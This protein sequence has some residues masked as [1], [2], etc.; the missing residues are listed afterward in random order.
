MIH[1]QRCILYALHFAKHHQL[2]QRR[3]CDGSNTTLAAKHWRSPQLLREN[4]GD[5]SSW[6]KVSYVFDSVHTA[7]GFQLSK[8][9]R[10]SLAC[11]AT[12][13][14]KE[15]QGMK[16]NKEMR[17]DKQ[18]KHKQNQTKLSKPE[19]KPSSQQAEAEKS[20]AKESKAGKAK[21]TN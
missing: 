16:E 4:Q 13:E 12:K 2:A 20:K 15:E 1:I 7:I 14:W 19:P 11:A 9:T 8:T 21:Q 10:L 18:Q 17:T 6:P 5:F 3:H